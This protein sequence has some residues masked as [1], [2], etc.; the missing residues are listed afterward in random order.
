MKIT[1]KRAYNKYIVTVD[2]RCYL[3]D[4]CREACEFLFSMHKTAQML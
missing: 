1:F 2:S 3:F 4:T